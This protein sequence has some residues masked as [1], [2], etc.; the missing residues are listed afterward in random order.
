VHLGDHIQVGWLTGLDSWEEAEG[1]KEMGGLGGQVRRRVTH[2][3]PESFLK[4]KDNER[5]ACQR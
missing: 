2:F 4:G 3:W 1:W 5:S